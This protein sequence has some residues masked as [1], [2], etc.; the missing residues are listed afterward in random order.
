MKKRQIFLVEN[1]ENTRL[2][3]SLI[4]RKAGYVVVMGDDC[5]SALKSIMELKK[6]PQPID[7]LVADIQRDDSNALLFIDEIRKENPALP[8]LLI[9]E[10]SSEDILIKFQDMDFI[11]FV[12][13]PFE[14]KELLYQIVAILERKEK[15]YPTGNMTLPA[16]LL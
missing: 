7:L 13:K 11:G 12:E 10:Y 2:I 3:L 15:F 14:P 8:I 1:E 16:E 9:T 5:E 6:T 4:L